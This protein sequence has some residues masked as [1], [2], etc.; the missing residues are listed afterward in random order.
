MLISQ[1]LAIQALHYLT[2]AILLPPILSF[3]ASRRA[4]FFSGG[5][6]NVN[7]VMS[8]HELAG[9]SPKRLDEA[10][11]G[12]YSGGRRLATSN[13]FRPDE[14][15]DS[16]RRWIIAIVWIIA[17]VADAYYIYSFIRK[18]RLVLDFAL[19]LLFNHL[20]L[21]TYYTAAFPTSFFYWAVMTLSAV[22]IITLAEQLCV[23][24]ELSQDFKPLTGDDLED[25]D[26]ETADN[27][28]NLE[29]A[30]LAQR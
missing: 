24:R 23:R 30:P 17:S 2:L 1:I 3:G 7:L 29:L 8:W 13:T 11:H 15:I 12:I 5:P 19:T 16:H 18:P 20:I 14:M 26:S 22:I 10:I 21:T 6:A 28:E 4:L 9:R 25:R 27:A